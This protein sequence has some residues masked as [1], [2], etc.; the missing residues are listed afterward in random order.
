PGRLDQQ[1][2]WSEPVSPLLH[3]WWAVWIFGGVMS[4][5]DATGWTSGARLRTLRTATGVDIA[6]EV[7][8]IVAACL[9]IAVIHTLTKRERERAAG[10][11][12]ATSSPRFVTR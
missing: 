4:R 9:A 3:W 1:P 6:T 2:T 7:T 10:V 8:S 5:V 12:G 11:S